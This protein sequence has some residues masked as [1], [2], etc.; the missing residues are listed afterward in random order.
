VWNNEHGINLTPDGYAD[1]NS[2]WGGFSFHPSVNRM[3]LYWE[4]EGGYTGLTNNVSYG[5][6]A[7]IA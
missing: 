1:P 7:G 5:T 4:L 3:D 6:G 2:E